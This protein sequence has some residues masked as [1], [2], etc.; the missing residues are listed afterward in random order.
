MP[1]RRGGLRDQRSNT[2]EARGFC[3]AGEFRCNGEY[4]LTCTPDALRLDARSESVRLRIS[5][6]RSSSSV[7]SAPSAISAATARRA[8]NAT[9]TGPRGTRS[10]VCD[11]TRCATRRSAA[12]A[13]RASTCAAVRTTPWT[14]SSGSAARATPGRCC[15]TPARRRA[16]AP[17][18]STWRAPIR[19]GRRRASDRCACLDAGEYRCEGQELQRCRQDLTGWDI[20]DTCASVALCEQGVQ[21][22][23]ISAG[24]VDMCPLGCTSPGAFVC[25]GPG[26]HALSRRSHRLRL[27]DDVRGGHATV[28]R[29]QGACTGPCTEG[30]VPVQRLAATA[31]PSPITRGKS[32]PAAHRRCSASRRPTASA[33][34]SGEC[35]PPA[36]PMAGE[37]QLRGRGALRMPA[38]FF[39]R[40]DTVENCHSAEL[41]SASTSAAT[42]RS[43]RRASSAASA[44]E[45]RGVAT[46]GSPAGTWSR[47][48][49]RAS[50]AR[51]IPA[52]PGCKL[53]CPSPTRCN[54]AELERCT[55]NGWVHSGELRDE[56]PLLVHL[57]RHVH[58]RDLDGRLRHAR[59]RRN[60]RRLSVH[61]RDA[62]E[63]PGGAK[64]LGHLCDLRFGGA[65]LPGR[66]ADVCDGLLRDLPDGGRGA[67]RHVRHGHRAFRRARPTERPGTPRR[68]AACTAAWTRARW[69]TAPSATPVRCSAA[70]ATL[71]R[72]GTERRSWVETGVRER[73]P[74]RR[75]GQ[76]VRHLHAELEPVRRPGAAPLLERRAARS[77]ADLPEPLRRRERRVR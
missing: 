60:A 37:L 35:L 41:C 53:E 50:S 6:I 27:R 33:R 11:P 22:A 47:P 14:A 4:L 30:D 34:P 65:L 74:L 40:W 29:V 8:R 75:G 24:L 13:R 59:V 51:T 72:C 25:E 73:R 31:L 43:A 56:R 49:S 70:R 57:D 26:A 12:T 66:R 54:G 67:L 16:S 20:V 38:G 71:Q 28:T 9:R 7:A 45:L 36:C 1:A 63:V 58:P 55:P 69:T 76:P 5:A 77:N 62:A 48:A 32:S 23:T 15:S 64:W 61:G 19:T 44:N 68:P 18:A 42:N 2:E 10:E 3:K 39:R 52:D 17:R 46:P 21:N